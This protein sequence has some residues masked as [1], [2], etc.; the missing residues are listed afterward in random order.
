[1]TK[2]ILGGVSMLTLSLSLSI[3]N[4]T[5]REPSTPVIVEKIT[6]DSLYDNHVNTIYNEINLEY[7][8]LSRSVFEKALTGFYNLKKSGQ[9]SEDKSILSIADFDKNST[10]KRLW[11]IDLNKKKLIL[12]TWVAHGQRSGADKA[13][14]FSN[15]ND[16]FQSSI[17]FYLTAE[18]Y[19]G[20]HGRSL[21]LDGMDEG[22][23]SNARRRSIVVHGADYVSQGTINALGRLGRSQGCP[24][25]PSELSDLVI[26]TIEGK[27]VLF[28]NVTDQRYTSI[29]LDEHMAAAFANNF[30]QKDS[31][32]YQDSTLTI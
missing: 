5:H 28:I 15:S 10:E 2:C 20:Q 19:R 27:T 1:M 14:R 11:I 7:T 17:G 30:N 3:F 4:G 25:V 8:G 13:T 29:Y 21:R 22:F 12:N 23:N 9:V 16:S 6:E 31:T 26:N 24:A 18:I 32:S